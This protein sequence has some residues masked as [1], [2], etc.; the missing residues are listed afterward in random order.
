L[1]RYKI[2]FESVEDPIRTEEF[3]YHQLKDLDIPYVGVSLAHIINKCGVEVAQ[4]A[5]D[6]IES[7]HPFEKIF[8]CQ[9]ILVNRLN[10][11]SNLVFTP[12]AE[13]GDGRFFL[14]HFNPSYSVRPPYI[15]TIEDRRLRMSF[16][17]AF[18]THETRPMLSGLSCGDVVIEET[19]GWFFYKSDE[20]RAALRA[21]YLGRL[22]D[23]K[24]SLCPRGTGVSTIRLFESLSVGS[25]PMV[26][27]GIELPPELEG[28][29][30]RMEIDDLLS[31]RFVMPSDEELQEASSFLYDYYWENLSNDNLFKSILRRLS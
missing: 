15:K 14:P 26:F 20:E 5:I 16:Q 21:N 13:R 1:I 10:F 2:A 4:A 9:H 18:R 27:N 23:S 28:K 11:G 17:G 31:G 6:E 12:H 7:K 19:G 3:V 22:N 30:I 8:V 25:V 29:V 24:I